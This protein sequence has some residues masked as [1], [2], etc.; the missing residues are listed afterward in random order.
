MN[1]VNAFFM[2]IGPNASNA[3]YKNIEFIF[4]EINK[5]KIRFHLLILNNIWRIIKKT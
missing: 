5:L 1:T 2:N 4:G 3:Y